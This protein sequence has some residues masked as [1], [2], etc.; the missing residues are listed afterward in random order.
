MTRFA[1]IG[2]PPSLS[3][4]PRQISTGFRSGGSF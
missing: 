4:M 2:N 3:L 1:I